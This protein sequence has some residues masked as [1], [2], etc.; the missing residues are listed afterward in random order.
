M[1]MYI[2][3]NMAVEK[4]THDIPEESHKKGQNRFYKFVYGEKTFTITLYYYGPVFP[5]TGE[6]HIHHDFNTFDSM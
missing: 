3:I 1:Y 6:H 2:F 5:Q 4:D